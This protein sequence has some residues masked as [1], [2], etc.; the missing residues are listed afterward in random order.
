M[1]ALVPLVL[2]TAAA[3]ANTAGAAPFRPSQDQALAS[4]CSIA[5]AGDVNNSNIL[6]CPKIAVLMD[7]ADIARMQDVDP[8]LLQLIRQDSFDEALRRI[9]RLVAEG[10][11]KPS[12]YLSIGASLAAARGMPQEA[13]IFAKRAYEADPTDAMLL[14]RYYAA[15]AANRKTDEAAALIA[16]ADRRR[17]ELKGVG[18]HLFDVAK[19]ESDYSYEMLDRWR[20]SLDR[21]L[22][23]ATGGAAEPRAGRGRS[24]KTCGLDPGA[25][26]SVRALRERALRL[27]QA[28][29][30]AAPGARMSLQ[31]RHYLLQY[32][33]IADELLQDTANAA[34]TEWRMTGLGRE[35]LKLFGPWT[36]LLALQSEYR[37]DLV[38]TPTHLRLKNQLVDLALDSA[39]A[40]P[41]VNLGVG[42]SDEETLPKLSGIMLASFHRNRAITANRMNENGV[43]W[44]NLVAALNAATR[45]GNSPVAIGLRLAILRVAV[46][47]IGTADKNFDRVLVA[48]E[49]RRLKAALSQEPELARTA[50]PTL[51]RISS[52]LCKDRVLTGAECAAG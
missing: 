24:S 51:D 14:L 39:P 8:L 4:N 20:V 12:V 11:P 18:L 42:T 13:L 44:Q 37:L 2:L 34:K 15:L 5:I 43:A 28:I 16:A 19:L 38:T 22:G 9:E 32:V 31:T 10:V 26:Q 52:L 35:M 50:G 46:E 45:Y 17:T 27:E 7:I 29:A 1:R 21:C 30:A 48:A 33:L 36:Y 40:S 49:H 23:Q 47:L 25:E 6:A 41:V 3:G